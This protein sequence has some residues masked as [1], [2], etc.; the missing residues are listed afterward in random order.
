MPTNFSSA[1]LSL[2]VILLGAPA[3]IPAQAAPIAK[4]SQPARDLTREEYNRQT[5]I[6]FYE[7]VFQRHEV[8]KSAEV[9]ADSYIQHNPGVPDGKA[10]FV[11]HF[12]GFFKNNPAAR[13]TI[14]RSAAEGDLV[15]L[16]V[17]STNG[18]TDR[19]RAIVDIF[20]V[21]N[22]RIVEHWDVIQ[23]VPE[24]AANS[25]TMF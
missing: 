11:N 4:Q 1:A 14:V 9:L 3:T 23:L 8:A 7:G 12:T 15:Y 10:P 5:V 21:A 6:A 18:N 16:H 17:H 25:N 19:G 13:S 20:R 24:K 2:S 22:G